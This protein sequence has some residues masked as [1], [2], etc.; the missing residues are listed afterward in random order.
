MQGAFFIRK[1]TTG[2]AGVAKRALATSI[3]MYTKKLL[4]AKLNGIR[5][6]IK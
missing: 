5:N 1:K 6:R 4:C 3:K 2:Y